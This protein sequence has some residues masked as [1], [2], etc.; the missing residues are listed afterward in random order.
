VPAGGLLEV[1]VFTLAGERYA[2]ETRHVREIRALED[3]TPLP[4]APVFLAGVTN[5]RGQ[6]LA[7]IDLR[8]FFGVPARGLTDRTRL[9]VLGD[10]RAEFGVLAD[11]VAEVVTLGPGEVRE[12]PGSVA[13]VARAYLRGVTGDALIVLAGEVL[14]QDPR[15]FIDQGDDAGVPAREEQA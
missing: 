4:G 12:P 9:I 8:T 5:L 7:V 3:L 11:T 14:L 15:L 10:E 1:V 2:L 13:G 6:I